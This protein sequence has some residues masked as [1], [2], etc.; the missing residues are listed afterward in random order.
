MDSAYGIKLQP[1]PRRVVVTDFDI[2]FLAMVRFTIKLALASVPAVL[3]ISLLAAAAAS[4]LYFALRLV[5]DSGAK[6]S[7]LPH[8]FRFS[9]SDSS[10]RSLK[11]PS[12]AR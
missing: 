7:Q 12:L 2:P 9:L 10:G 5:L 4:L 6:P 8:L 3:I 11:R 1:D